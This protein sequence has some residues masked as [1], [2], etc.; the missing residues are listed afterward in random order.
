MSGDDHHPL[1]DTLD[2]QA[3]ALREVASSRRPRPYPGG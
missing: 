2:R 1:P 3:A